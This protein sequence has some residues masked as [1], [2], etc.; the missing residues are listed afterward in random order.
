ME[1]RKHKYSSR[2]AKKIDQMNDEIVGN[3]LNFMYIY[4]KPS[5]NSMMDG[6]ETLNAFLLNSSFL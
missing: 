5:I 6:G 4:E 2:C 1:N 3:F